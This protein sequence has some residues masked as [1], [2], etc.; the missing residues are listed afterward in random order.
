MARHY[1][2][3]VADPEQQCPCCRGTGRVHPILEP[4][5][6]VLIGDTTAF[7]VVCAGTGRRLLESL[8]EDEDNA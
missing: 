3:R 8:R 7:C 5:Q 1:P 4:W 6:Q 2:P